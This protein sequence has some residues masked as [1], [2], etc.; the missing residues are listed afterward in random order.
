VRHP[1]DPYELLEIPCQEL[2][3]IVGDDPRLGVR[4]FLSGSLE[5]DLDLGLG[6]RLAQIP[7]DNRPAVAVLTIIGKT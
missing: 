3:S 1:G 6:H 4:I 7:V 5:N 2:R